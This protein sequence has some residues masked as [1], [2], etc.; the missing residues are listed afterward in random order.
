MEQP[1]R[2]ILVVCQ[3]F[4]PE[5]FRINDICEGFTE[6]DIEVDVLCG[7]PNYPTGEWAEGYGPWKRRVE[8]HGEITVYRSFEIRRKGNTSLRILL[9][10]L[11]FPVSSAHR[12]RALYRNRYDR[13]FIY[14]L[15]PVYM[16]RAGLKIA[17]KQRIRSVTYVMDLWPENL[18]SVINFKNKL[19]R[20]ILFKTSVKYYI[21]SD[22]LVCLT[23]K[24]K[25]ILAQRT[26]KS[27]SDI[28]VMPQCPEKIYS[29]EMHD[30][31]LH[32]RFDGGFN[33]VYAGNISP[34]QDFPCMIE[35]ARRLEADGIAANWII[36]GDG[37]SRAESEDAVKRAGLAHRFFFEGMKPMEDVPKYT[38]IASGLV[39]CL[40]PSALLECTVPA[41][42]TSYIAAGR[43][44]V[45]AMNGEAGETVS[46]AE[47]GFV[48]AAGDA[49]AMYR[50]LKRLYG[51]G[52]EGRR[53]MGENAKRLYLEK[54]ERDGNLAKLIDFIFEE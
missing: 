31:E 40:T 18:Y 13:V 5:N 23:E 33:L 15:S 19:I 52:A 46:A 48:G 17:K 36:V 28:L 38:D 32:E 27:D 8:R 12:V 2:R 51:L 47:C 24:A 3:H 21:K 43:P 4:W 41:K 49:E 37:M 6:N 53:K 16:G 26:G 9:N 44:T 7:E 34:A 50:N 35:A 45:L 14:S 22:R 20:K 54:Y 30:A 10:Y 42:V 29:E 39:A 25:Q 11:T 1:K